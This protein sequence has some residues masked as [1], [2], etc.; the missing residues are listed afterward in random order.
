MHRPTRH[1]RRRSPRFRQHPPSLRIPL[2][3]RSLPNLRSPRNLP[4]PPSPPLRQ[5]PQPFRLCWCRHSRALPPLPALPLLP[6]LPPLDVP[7]VPLL[8]SSSLPHAAAIRAIAKKGRKGASFFMVF[9]QSVG[10]TRQP[11][12]DS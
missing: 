12:R 3:L 2:S 11:R 9:L 8:E 4:S 10:R 5:M 7:P 1:L 6:A